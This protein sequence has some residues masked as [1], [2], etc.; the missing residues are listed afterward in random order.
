MADEASNKPDAMIA[1]TGWPST[2]TSSSHPKLSLL[3]IRRQTKE[4]TLA[5]RT[6]SIWL[7]L[8]IS[9][10]IA[11]DTADMTYINDGGQTTGAVASIAK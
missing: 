11:N 6:C 3:R 8:G 9:H 1:E 10:L 2:G 4:G 7:T 5:F